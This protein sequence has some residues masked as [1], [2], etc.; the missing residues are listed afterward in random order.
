MQTK[1]SDWST[2]SPPSVQQATDLIE[3]FESFLHGVL[4]LCFTFDVQLLHQHLKMLQ[5]QTQ[6]NRCRYIIYI[7]YI[8]ICIYICLNINTL[9][10][11]V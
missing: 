4:D 3:D 11:N 10:K 8:Y 5:T 7:K 2:N 9:I 1:T 6:V